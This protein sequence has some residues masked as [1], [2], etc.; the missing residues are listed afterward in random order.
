MADHGPNLHTVEGPFAEQT[1]DVTTPALRWLLDHWLEKR[2]ERDCPRWRDIDLPSMYKHAP[3]IVVKDAID[4]GRDFRVRFW[5]TAVTEWLRHDA[6]GRLLSDYFPAGGR[7]QI[8]EAHRLALLGDTP[9]RRWGVSVYPDRGYVAFE[10]ITLPL[11]NDAG[12]RAHILS[13]SLYRMI[14]SKSPPPSD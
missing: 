5:G 6:T 12:D 9:V 4:G 7:A 13:M 11:A 10:T 2:G 8:L 14:D 1:W 3:N